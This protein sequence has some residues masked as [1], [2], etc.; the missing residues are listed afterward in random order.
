[1]P[2]GP[3]IAKADADPVRSVATPNENRFH[4]GET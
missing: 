2:P 4:A 3:P 1:M